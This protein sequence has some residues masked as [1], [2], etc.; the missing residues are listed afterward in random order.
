[1]IPT[2]LIAPRSTSI[3]FCRRPQRNHALCIAAALAMA[4]HANGQC[5]TSLDTGS[6]NPVGI[7]T[8]FN[9]P[10]CSAVADFNND[11]RL[12]FAAANQD[13]WNV[14]I[15]VGIGDG[16]FGVL[17]DY[18]VGIEP[19]FIV[20]ADFNGDTFADLATANHGSSSVSILRGNGSGN[21]A[22]AVNYAAGS[23][24]ICLAVADFNLD[25][26]PDIAV[27]NKSGGN[28]SIL[29]GNSGVNVGTFQPPVNY[30]TTRAH[31]QTL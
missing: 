19:Y 31:S 11:G 26:V 18:D 15:R 2:R 10:L 3:T 20:T 28:I 13:G 6:T 29:F 5:A 12:D 27:A 8:F 4:S 21:F 14:S 25:G 9:T 17:S 30:T 22:A 24:P 16:T 7:F 1:M 23:G